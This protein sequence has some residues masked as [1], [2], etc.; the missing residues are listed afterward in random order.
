[1]EGIRERIQVFE[2]VVIKRRGGGVSETFTV[3]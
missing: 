2:G 1:M 3:A